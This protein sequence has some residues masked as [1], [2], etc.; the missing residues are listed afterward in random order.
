[1]ALKGYFIQATFEDGTE[2]SAYAAYDGTWYYF[3][4]DRRF[5]FTL[6]S[7]GA[8]DIQQYQPIGSN[9]AWYD[10]DI[11]TAVSVEQF[12]PDNSG[13]GGTVPEDVY[14]KEEV[15][16]LIAEAVAEVEAQIPDLVAQAVQEAIG[17]LDD[18]YVLKA[19]DTMTGSLRVQNTA[20]RYSV[21]SATSCTVFGEENNVFMN[22][23][24]GFG[25]TTASGQYKG[26]L[27]Q[28]GYYRCN[29]PGDNTQRVVMNYTGV[30]FYYQ[31]NYW[32]WLRRSNERAYFT[33]RSD[34][35]TNYSQCSSEDFVVYRNGGNKIWI[36]T[37]DDEGDFIAYD[38]SGNNTWYMPAQISA[39]TNGGTSQSLI[40]P[41]ANV[42]S[43]NKAI[44]V[45]ETGSFLVAGKMRLQAEG[46]NSYS[47]RI[48]FAINDLNR[49]TFTDFSGG[50]TGIVVWNQGRII[51]RRNTEAEGGSAN[52]SEF[53]YNYANL[54]GN[55]NMYGNTET[56]YPMYNMYNGPIQNATLRFQMYPTMNSVVMTSFVDWSIFR[57]VDAYTQIGFLVDSNDIRMSIAGGDVY[58]SDLV[59][60]SGATDFL[61]V[62]QITF[63]DENNSVVG[64]INGSSPGRVTLA[65]SSGDGI[66]L[67]QH[68]THIVSTDGTGPLGGQITIAD[69]FTRSMAGIINF[70]SLEILASMVQMPKNTTDAGKMGMDD[71]L[72]DAINDALN[73]V[74]EWVAGRLG[75][76]G[77]VANFLIAATEN[78]IN[79]V[80]S[81]QSIQIGGMTNRTKEK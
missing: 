7:A 49:V 75:V 29:P 37:T 39:W 12:D 32:A 45:P 48:R 3:Y 9:M 57:N 55:L 50:Y 40:T 14:T 21:L 34:N 63:K 30:T 61:Q 24:T 67:N 4:T 53:G 36:R 78:S 5:R 73:Y 15:Q 17:G 10:I 26:R 71:S 18:R 22:P 54:C 74:V 42:I 65:N 47:T 41:G 16:Q 80:R 33:I 52:S 66:V 28:D 20:G 70:I 8:V 51:C 46:L 56:V 31:N 76:S 19:G 11:I 43:F 60:S 13:G 27:D 77:P 69:N 1:M 58:V 2:V 68:N 6:T 38:S 72:V 44:Q 81:V 23:S 59:N 62:R 35:A 64:Y 79:Q 25:V